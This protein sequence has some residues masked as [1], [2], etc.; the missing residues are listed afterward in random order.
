MPDDLIFLKDLGGEQVL[1]ELSEAKDHFSYQRASPKSFKTRRPRGFGF[2][3]VWELSPA[4][5]GMDFPSFSAEKCF[6]SNYTAGKMW[7]QV[8]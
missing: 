5:V 6:A 3:T 2:Q 1:Q 7:R 4:L 8:P